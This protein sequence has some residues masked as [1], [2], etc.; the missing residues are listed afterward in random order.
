M[1]FQK[2]GRTC[3]PDHLRCCTSC[4]WPCQP[5]LSSLPAEASQ[6]HAVTE[7]TG[8]W[9]ERW[10]RNSENVV[11]NMVC[12]CIRCTPSCCIPPICQPWALSPALRWCAG[13]RWASSSRRA[14]EDAYRPYPLPGSSSPLWL[15]QRPACL[16]P[17]LAPCMPQLTASPFS[18]RDFSPLLQCGLG[19]SSYTGNVFCPSRAT[20][21]R[22]S[23]LPELQVV[24]LGKAVPICTSGAGNL[25]R[26]PPGGVVV[27]TICGVGHRKL[28]GKA[29]LLAAIGL[30]QT[31]GYLSWLNWPGLY[32]RVKP[33]QKLL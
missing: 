7:E 30:L 33:L 14:M 31:W 1:C 16:Y 11:I 13:T 18:R 24:I 32:L 8:S 28:W 12:S 25:K 20:S 9:Y 19:S 4:I 5:L 6:C 26:M 21:W 10:P 22:P 23:P 29:A 17:G 15:C 3:L 27:V 2:R